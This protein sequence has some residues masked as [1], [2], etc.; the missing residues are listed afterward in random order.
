MARTANAELV[1]AVTLKLMASSDKIGHLSYSK[2]KSIA[3]IAAD[4]VYEQIA[5]AARRELF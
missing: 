5:I 1:E 2:A 3:R 4:E